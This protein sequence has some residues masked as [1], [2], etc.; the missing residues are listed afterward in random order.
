MV[1]ITI[2]IEIGQV[3]RIT[4]NLYTRNVWSAIDTWH[5]K[6][7]DYFFASQKK[8]RID[9]RLRLADWKFSLCLQKQ[10]VKVNG[11]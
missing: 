5:Q 1:G 6:N 11:P 2:E 4:L 7:K 9:F 3:S 8:M 10:E